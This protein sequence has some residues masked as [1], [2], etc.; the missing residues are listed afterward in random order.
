MLE[1][2]YVGAAGAGPDGPHVRGG[3]SLDHAAHRFGLA[4]TWRAPR[5]SLMPYRLFKDM[6]DVELHAIYAYLQT[7]PPKPYGN[8]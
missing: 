7:V 4:R 8:R 2:F 5:Q 6:T 1:P 3:R